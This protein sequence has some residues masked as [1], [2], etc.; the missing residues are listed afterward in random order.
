MRLDPSRLDRS[1]ALG[2]MGVDSLMS[3]ELR[4]R[5][6]IDLGIELTVTLLFTYPTVTALAGHL[7]S[8]LLQVPSAEPPDPP[9]AEP[10]A[11]AVAEEVERLSDREL[12]ALFDKSFGIA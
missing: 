7:L 3:L 10:A 9:P 6:E 8:D 11:S 5:L 4:N 12:L 1:K 2:E